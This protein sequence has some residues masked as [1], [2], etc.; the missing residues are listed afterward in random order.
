MGLQFSMQN[1]ADLL[2]YVVTMIL[3]QPVQFRW[4]ALIS[5]VAVFLGVISY[6]VSC[7]RNFSLLHWLTSSAWNYDRSTSGWKEAMYSILTV[8]RYF[9]NMYDCI[10]QR[11]TFTV[12]V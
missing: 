6:T 11:H 9:G 5:F 7:T 8:Y 3:S 2:K 10:G 12:M 4:A 1:M